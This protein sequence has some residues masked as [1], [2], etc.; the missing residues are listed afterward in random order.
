LAVPLT[1][2]NRNDVTQLV[3]LPEAIP[4][5]RETLLELGC[6][7]ICRRR[8]HPSRSGKFLRCSGPPARL[9]RPTPDLDAVGAGP[10]PAGTG[11]GRVSVFSGIAPRPGAT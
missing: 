6:G 3:P 4:P 10:V 2:G 7:L 8:R 5:I 9:R 1:G 11:R